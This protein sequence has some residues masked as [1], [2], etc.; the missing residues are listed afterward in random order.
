MKLR[1]PATL[2]VPVRM[3]AIVQAAIPVRRQGKPCPAIQNHSVQQRARI[4]LL[5]LVAVV[6]HDAMHAG[7]A[8]LTSRRIEVGRSIPLS[9]LSFSFLRVGVPPY[10]QS[11]SSSDF[12]WPSR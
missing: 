9:D 11:V 1:T 3:A 6:W 5:S 8:P 7:D 4:T 12:A 10:C 2:C